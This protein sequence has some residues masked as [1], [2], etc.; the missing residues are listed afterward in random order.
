MSNSRFGITP[1]NNRGRWKNL[2]S[3]VFNINGKEIFFRSRWEANYALYQRCLINWNGA[4]AEDL[5]SGFFETQSLRIVDYIDENF[6]E[7]MPGPDMRVPMNCNECS[8]EIVLSMESSD[9]L[10]RT[11]KTERT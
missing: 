6:M 10:F 1:K 11:P 8:A 4:P 7:N 5:P 2:A 3:G 9:F